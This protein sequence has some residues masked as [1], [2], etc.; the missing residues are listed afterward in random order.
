MLCWIQIG[1]VGDVEILFVC[2]LKPLLS[3]P[4]CLL[5]AFSSQVLAFLFLHIV[6]SIWYYWGVYLYTPLNARCSEILIS[7]SSNVHFSNSHECQ[8]FFRKL[9]TLTVSSADCAFAYCKFC[10]LV[11]N[12]F[13]SLCVLDNSPPLRAQL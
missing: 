13:R 1:I 10:S 12:I 11:F 5:I 6:I 3:F 4:H 9:L 2:V 7:E 8:T